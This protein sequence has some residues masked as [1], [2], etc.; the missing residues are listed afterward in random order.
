MPIKFIISSRRLNYLHNILS[1]EKTDLISRV[2]HAQSESPI[3]GDFVKLIEKDFEL[4]NEPFNPTL[5]TSMSKN[6]FKKLVKIKI[7]KAAF[8][9]SY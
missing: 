9:F 1:R 7:E 2:F 4:I 5:I 3:E 6:Q 8:K